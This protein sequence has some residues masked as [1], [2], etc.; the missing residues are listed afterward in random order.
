MN[1]QQVNSAIMF[2]SFTTVELDSIISAVKMAR[3]ALTIQNKRA[4][5]IGTRVRWSSAKNP[6]G[7][8]GVVEK[9]ATKFVTVR[10]DSD[11]RWRVPASML[12][13]V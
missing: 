7:E 10:T 2:G 9:I 4:M 5:R 1:I 6:R 8:C 3:A 11:F 13:V 12:E